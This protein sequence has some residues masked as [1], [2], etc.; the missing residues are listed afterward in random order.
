MDSGRKGTLHTV[1]FDPWTLRK[2]I[3]KPVE[4]HSTEDIRGKHAKHGT[5]QKEKSVAEVKH[6]GIK[7]ISKPNKESDAV[8]KPQDTENKSERSG[9][10]QQDS[11]RAQVAVQPKPPGTSRDRIKNQGG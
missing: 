2:T 11:T 1:I 10:P 7:N 6:Q 9:T 3:R 5:K 8:V 4:S